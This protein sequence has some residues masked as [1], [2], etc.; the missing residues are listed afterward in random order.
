MRKI[1]TFQLNKEIEV[2]EPQLSK[3][4]KGEDVKTL[5]KTKKQEPHNYFLARPNRS[6]AEGAELFYQKIFWM[7]QKEGILPMSQL[8]KRL[9]DDGGILNKEEIEWREKS[10]N[11]FLELQSEQK[12]L[13]EKKDKT[14]E[15]NK[16]LDELMTEIVTIYSDIQ[17]FE[18][19]KSGNLIQNTAE[20]VAKNRQTLY[21]ALFLSQEDLGDNKTKPVFGNGTYEERLAVYDKI[22]EEDDRYMNQLV[23][24]LFLSTSLWNLN[25]VQTQE[26]FE[27]SIRSAEQ[28]GLIDAIKTITKTEDKKEEG[29][30]PNVPGPQL[31][32]ELDKKAEEKVNVTETIKSE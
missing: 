8:S 19:S 1:F 27:I 30:I 24:R 10:F 21:W 3:N 4:D 20:S 14:E 15:D 6:I 9:S 17:E 12:T 18:Q 7:C 25:K 22:E 29:F 5:V 31:Q 26:E 13:N 2:E 23:Q 32:A 28:Q 11:K 16:K